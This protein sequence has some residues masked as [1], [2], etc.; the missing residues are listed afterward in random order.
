VTSSWRRSLVVR[1][2][3]DNELGRF[4]AEL[5]AHHWLG[6]RLSGQVMRYVAVL[7][8]QWVA[9]AGFG[10]AALSC[11]VREQF[12]GWDAETKR[13]RLPL[14]VCSQ[15]LCV[16]PAGRRPHLASAVLGAC[17]R[18]L[19][20]DYA[21]RHGRSVLA[22]ETFTD[23]ARHTGAC[24]AAAGFTPVGPTAGIGRSR[25]GTLAHG[26]PKTYWFKP[27]HPRA[28][29][30]LAADFDVTAVA[31]P[32]TPG[33]RSRMSIPRPDPNLLDWSS[34]RDGLL[35]ALAGIVDP[36]KPRGK[37]HEL[38]SVLAVAVCAVLAGSNGPFAIAQYA[39][40]LSQPALAR[41]GVRHN[42]RLG[43]RLPPSRST[44]RRALRTLDPDAFDQCVSA[45][46]YRQ[47]TAGSLTPAHLDRLSIAVD[48]K[49]VRGATKAGQPLHL[50]AAIAHST[51]AVLAQTAV[52]TKKG[53]GSQ[54]AP[55][56]DHIADL[57]ANNTNNH[58][59]S[60][61][62][63]HNDDS[64]HDDDHHG[65]GGAQQECPVSDP[66]QPGKLANIIL[67]AD[68]LHTT[69]ANAK[70][71]TAD[72]GDYILIVKANQPKLH[73]QINNL[74]WQDAPV[75]DETITTGHGRR[76][77]RVLKVLPADQVDGITFP[78]ANTVF[79]LERYRYNKDGKLISAAAVLGVTSCDT[80]ELPPAELADAIRGDWSIEVLH[81]IRDVTFGE[82]ASTLRQGPTPRVLATLRNLA[83][84]LLRRYDYSASATS[85][86][87]AEKSPGTITGSP[88]T[89]SA[90]DI[91]HNQTTV[92]IRR[93]R[94]GLGLPDGWEA[95]SGR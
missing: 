75:A 54:L 47:V 64:D 21:A 71:V 46:L 44:I 19:G 43:R 78:G 28:A 31:V 53:E 60:D 83:I 87:P 14:L 18:R 17:L 82:D 20:A 61:D 5:R 34:P 93:S 67:T 73:A 55:V 76:D 49:T 65:G 88:S 35:A 4:R 16:L 15:R 84:S 59:D 69:K 72:G 42:T 50:F 10:S 45:W 1:P 12:L 9:L 13:R 74:P 8:G 27:L 91:H 56:L 23:P 25:A 77:R 6:F 11:T 26:Q 39:A 33:G 32:L 85:P 7:D 90:C 81:W 57:R 68:A 66:S 30:L 70:R 40:K 62:D 3:A 89:S 41:L 36:R 38:A 63:H 80:T 51:G 95:G 94:G 22:V 86:Q 24:Y 2:V 79:L 29:A 37:R 58:N 48:G 52:P 92:S